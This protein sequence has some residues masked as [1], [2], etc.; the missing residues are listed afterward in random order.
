M[1]PPTRRRAV[2]P[3][4][5]LVHGFE[6][7]LGEEGGGARLGCSAYAADARSRDWY[8]TVY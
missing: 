5:H 7:C 6:E 1:T 3:S 8:R 2:A 4:I